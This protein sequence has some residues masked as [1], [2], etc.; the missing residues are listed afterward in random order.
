MAGTTEP[1]PE[2][3]KLGIKATIAGLIFALLV[4]GGFGA[5][6]AAQADDDGYGDDKQEVHSDD[7]GHGED[8]DASD[9]HEAD[10]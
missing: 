8:H 1:A 10:Q 2:Q 4:L 3:P 5:A 6:V 7:D 9:D